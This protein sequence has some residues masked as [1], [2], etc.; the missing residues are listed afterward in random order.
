[1][2]TLGEVESFLQNFKVKYKIFD[3]VFR[4]SRDKNANT[5]LLL[6]MP[7]ARRREILESIV[8]ADY[9]EGPLDDRLYGIASLW[10]FGK[11]Y[12]Q[13]EIYIKISMGVTNAPVIC[14]SFHPAE[15]PMNYL[16]KNQ[17]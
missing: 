2:S 11:I 12:Q 8:A 1:M 13:K 15:R 14:I 10:V 6:D 9:T 5:L 16:Y 17:P 4:D 7:P 3:I